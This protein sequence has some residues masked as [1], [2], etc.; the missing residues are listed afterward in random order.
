MN[1]ADVE[2]ARLV[3]EVGMGQPVAYTPH[4]QRLIATHEA[5]HAVAAWL[6]A[7]QRRLEV[8]T[9]IKRKD[10]LGMLAHGDAEDVFTRSRSEM[11]ALMQIAMG[12]QAAE[13][14]FFDDISTGPAGD[15]LYATNVAAQMIG[16]A[17]MTD[18]LISYAAVQGSAL[19]DTNLVGKVLGDAEGRARVEKLLQA[20]KAYTLALLNENRHLVEAL[21]DALVERHELIGREIT[22]ILEAASAAKAEADT[23]VDVRAAA[24]RTEAAVTLDM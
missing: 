3:E 24:V 16:S 2:R 14:L 4:E 21:R 17:G 10:A 19:S 22:D 8:L 7:P 15:L 5:G 12:G 20:Q 9:I 13:E 18:T 1:R 23:V 11:I 6:T